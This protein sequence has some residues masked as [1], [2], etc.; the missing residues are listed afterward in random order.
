[1]KP[2]YFDGFE[3]NQQIISHQELKSN[4]IFRISAGFVLLLQFERDHDKQSIYNSSSNFRLSDKFYQ[5]NF[6]SVR[7]K[8]RELSELIR[9]IDDDFDFYDIK[10]TKIFA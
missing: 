10:E 5:L 7:V 4:F 1:M 2:K 3:S 9:L 6:F 8:L